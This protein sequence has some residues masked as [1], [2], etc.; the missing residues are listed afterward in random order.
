MKKASRFFSDEERELVEEAVS[1]A[2]LRTSGEIVPVVATSSGRY[3]RAEDL[4]GVLV[5]LAALAGAWLIFQD[6]SVAERAWDD[7]IR[8]TLTL[9]PTLLIVLVGFVV[10]AVIATLIPELRL[11]FV[12]RGE[13]EAEVERAA[14]AAFQELR[15]RGTAGGTG[16]LVYLS[17]FERMVHV[18]GD[19][20]ISSKVDPERW[21][22]VCDVVVA[23]VKKRR[24]AQGLSDGILSCGELLSEH[25]PIE[26]GDRD[27]LANT[28]H[29]LD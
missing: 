20:A 11:P 27:E 29:I 23:G 22:E 18:L 16:V 24:P 15:V 17:L 10:G 3:D 5:A 13:M 25:F 6:V 2:E 19:E 21:Q 28:L 1:L 8:P 14:R 26:P 9:L 7:Q 4:F 12:T